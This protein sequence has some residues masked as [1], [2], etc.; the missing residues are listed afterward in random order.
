MQIVALPHLSVPKLGL[1]DK[2]QGTSYLPISQSQFVLSCYQGLEYKA[3]SSM[4]YL[5]SRAV[6]SPLSPLR[7]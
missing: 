3:T 5:F 7:D 4:D 2:P 6:F 1:R